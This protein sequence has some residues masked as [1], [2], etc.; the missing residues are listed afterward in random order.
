[1]NYKRRILVSLLLAS[2]I[3]FGMAAFANAGRNI[4]TT[5]G[6]LNTVMVTNND[7]GD[8]AFEISP[9]VR[10]KSYVVKCNFIKLE[11]TASAWDSYADWACKDPNADCSHL[12]DGMREAI[13]GVHSS[14]EMTLY[15]PDGHV[16][17]M[18]PELGKTDWFGKKIRFS[19]DNTH[20]IVRLHC[21]EG[22][23]LYHF[24]FE[25]K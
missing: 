3:T 23:G 12:V 13:K 5:S 7:S 15:A 24:V 16:V 18:V 19:A 10:G 14:A 8:V 21:K 20:Y 17:G 4:W 6:V 22:A 11:E 2:Y 1:M 25:Y 9:P